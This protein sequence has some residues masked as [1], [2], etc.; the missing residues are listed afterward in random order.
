MNVGM[1]HKLIFYVYVA[2]NFKHRLMMV[3]EAKQ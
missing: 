2:K 1:L 3:Y